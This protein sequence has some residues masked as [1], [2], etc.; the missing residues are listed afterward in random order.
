MTLLSQ[1]RTATAWNGRSRGLAWMRVSAVTMLA[2]AL[3]L[4]ATPSWASNESSTLPADASAAVVRQ[5]P[6]VWIPGA[7][8]LC[9]RAN[10]QADS[11]LRMCGLREQLEAII[12]AE[13]CGDHP[14]RPWIAGAA[15]AAL[16]IVE[17]V[18][19]P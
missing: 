8:L 19:A 3:M 1:V 12:S 7:T 10:A 6:S 13:V 2:Q 16:L 15:F 11:S 18:S 5:G 4:L 9:Q 14:A 17:L